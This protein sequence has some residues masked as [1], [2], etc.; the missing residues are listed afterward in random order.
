MVEKAKMDS[1][2]DAQTDK[3]NA[4]K[5][6]SSLSTI[7]RSKLPSKQHKQEP[8]K[9]YEEEQVHSDNAESH[10]ALLALAEYLGIEQPELS[11][12]QNEEIS[13]IIEQHLTTQLYN[14]Q[15]DV[16]AQ[17]DD[18]ERYLEENT[19]AISPQFFKE[20]LDI[21]SQRDEMSH[22]YAVYTIGK[23]IENFEGDQ[24]HINESINYISQ[25]KHS[26]SELVRLT[27]LQSL[28][29]VINDV[30]KLQK[31]LSYFDNDNSE[32][33]QAKLKLLRF[34]MDFIERNN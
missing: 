15:G 2:S 30:E 6:Q 32:L 8:I 7:P 28:S 29:V 34:E 19:S 11:G 16:Y 33:V 25:A 3:V 26:S 31:E 22:S 9:K 27:V 23:A 21:A 5:H 18:I 14:A 13:L 12:Y 4:V 20:V 10:E 24:Q 17:F 1:F